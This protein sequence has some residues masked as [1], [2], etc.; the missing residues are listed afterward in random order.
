[1]SEHEGRDE[2]PDVDEQQ[3]GATPD[4]GDEA[5]ATPPEERAGESVGGDQGRQDD[6]Q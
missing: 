4:V 1:M 2:A 3:G 6:E 5:A